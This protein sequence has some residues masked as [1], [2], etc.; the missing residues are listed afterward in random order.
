MGIG[1]GDGSGYHS[2]GRCLLYPLLFLSPS[3]SHVCRF[4][5]MA[6]RFSCGFLVTPAR[7]QETQIHF[8]YFADTL[9]YLYFGSVLISNFNRFST[10]SSKECVTR[11]NNKLSYCLCCMLNS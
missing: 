2:L 7:L 8:F 10:I 5:C 3:L 9:L 6:L 4:I 11:E 1:G